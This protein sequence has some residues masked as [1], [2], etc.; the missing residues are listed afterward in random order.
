MPLPDLL[1]LSLATWGLAYLLTRE[2]GP[3]DILKRLRALFV[4]GGLTGCIYCAAVWLAALNYALLQTAAAPVVYIA[5]AY[6]GA[7]LLV[8]RSGKAGADRA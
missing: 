2:D 3:Y 7:M 4:F 6:G 5:A 1:I 8:A